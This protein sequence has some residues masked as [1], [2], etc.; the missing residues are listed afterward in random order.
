MKAYLVFLLDGTVVGINTYD[1]ADVADAQFVEFSSKIADQGMQQSY[2][3]S[4]KFNQVQRH[5][6]FG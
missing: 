4:Y 2:F 5:I 3:P 1:D 6:E